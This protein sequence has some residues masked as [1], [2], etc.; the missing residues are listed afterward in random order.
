[1]RDF[2]RAMKAAQGFTVGA[3]LLLAAEARSTRLQ[4][5]VGYITDTECGPSHAAMLKKGGMGSDDRSC[6]LKCVE[7]G[8]TFGF[9]DR[10]RKNF[11]Q[12][13]DQEKPKTFAGRKVR[14]LGHRKGDTIFIESIGPA[15]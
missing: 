9:V 10:K 15:K 5:F 11:Y 13:D 2:R 12:L 6:T 4:G 1:M 7:K 8:A 14:I 3:L